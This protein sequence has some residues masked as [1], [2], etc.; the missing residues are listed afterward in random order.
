[1]TVTATW[2]GTA[3]PSGSN[4]LGL[5][6]PGAP[7][8][9]FYLYGSAG[10]SGASGSVPFGLQSN[11]TPGTYELRLF[12][13]GYAL[14]ATSNS[15]TVNPLPTVSGTLSL[16]GAALSDVTFTATNGVTCTMLDNSVDYSCSVPSGWSGSV[17]PSRSGF[18]F[19]PASRTYNNVTTN[20]TA[21]DFTAVNV[22]TAEVYYIHP[23]HLNTVR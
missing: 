11:A 5:F 12:G 23:D 22:G 20:Q 1:S 10:A 13:G 8:T 15:F 3:G 19:T 7:S 14:L 18:S 6:N 2:S 9:G 21:Q 4:W 16:G 17:T